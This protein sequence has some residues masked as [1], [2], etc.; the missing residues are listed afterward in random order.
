MTRDENTSGAAAKL[1]VVHASIDPYWRKHLVIFPGG[2]QSEWMDSKADADKVAADFNKHQA[3]LPITRKVTFH[4]T[5][6]AALAWARSFN[7]GFGM[8]SR[9]AMKGDLRV[10]AKS[11][12]GWICLDLRSA[13]NA[14]MLYKWE[15]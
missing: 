2:I 11:A 4:K 14:G 5:E 7:G 15:A 8:N 10:V 6:G 13:I 3:K 12:D 1:A 9:R